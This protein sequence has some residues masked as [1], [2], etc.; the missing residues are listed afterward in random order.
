MQRTK[1]DLVFVLEST[2]V[3]EQAS[4]GI[5]GAGLRDYLAPVAAAA[6]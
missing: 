2:Y 4:Q 5:I 6:G 3:Y 1:P